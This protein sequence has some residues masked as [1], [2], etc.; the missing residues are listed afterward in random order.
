MGSPGDSSDTLIT[1]FS[2]TH[3]PSQT[4]AMNTVSAGSEPEPEPEPELELS[5][6]EPA[7]PIVPKLLREASDIT[8]QDS[9]DSNKDQVVLIR[10]HGRFRLLH[11]QQF[12]N[13][14]LASVGY[15]ELA[16]AGDFAANVWNEIPVPT[17]AAVLMGI[18]G[19]LAL[20]MVLV[21]IQDF[22]LSWR[23]VTLLRA[24][25]EHI[26][27]LRQHHN[28]NPEL[29]QLMNS[30]LGV[31]YR[32][33]GTEV[34]DRIVMD[35]LMGAGSVL[36][37]VG[38][39]MAIGG[40]NPR[41]YKASNLLSGYIGNALAAFFGVVNAVW[42]ICLI[43]RFQQHD[44]AARA[45]QPSDDIRRRLHTRVRRF[46]W[47]SF[48]NGLNG[49]VA[50]AGSMVTAERWWGYIVLIPCIISLIM[51]NYFWRKKLGYDRPILDE[52]SISRVQLTPLLED[53]EYAI[54]MQRA[55][56]EPDR[57]HP[58][59]PFQVHS[60]ESILQFIMRNRMLEIYCD[61]LVQ[62][63]KTRSLL[64]DIPASTN[65]PQQITI[66]HDVLLRLATVQPSHLQTLTEHAGKFL[67]TEGVRV[68]THRERHLLELLGYAVWLDQ[69]AATMTPMTSTAKTE[70]PAATTELKNNI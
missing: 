25:R 34:V 10:R 16:N 33:I 47:H 40:A 61:S 67:R 65:V 57:S 44:N 7:P 54:A 17:F 24:E 23:N 26:K 39:L 53:L 68:F 6:V 55:L 46:Q 27:R 22:R 50:G 64:Q 38:T 36:V 70:A 18:G 15:L 69:T 60:L 28:K 41:V 48:I 3:T 45:S 14:L 51:C 8:W 42:S 29:V 37:G 32:E 63:K 4:P 12:R 59:G 52:I 62:D 30:R 13:S 5:A 20:G 9:L 11:Q 2:P 66:S 43:R 56:A 58:H 19:T 21:A 31:S 49:L 1:P 35:L